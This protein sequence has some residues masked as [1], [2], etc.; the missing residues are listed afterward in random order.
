MR[1]GMVGICETDNGPDEVLKQQGVK[2]DSWRLK[3]KDSLQTNPR[4]DRNIMR[5]RECVRESESGCVRTVKKSCFFVSLFYLMQV[6]YKYL[7]K[8]ALLFECY[9]VSRFKKNGYLFTRELR[10]WTTQHFYL[11]KI[12]LTVN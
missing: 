2:E 6:W 9:F 10:F 11:C 3:T 7:Y 1:K 4:I 5:E 8:N 12:L